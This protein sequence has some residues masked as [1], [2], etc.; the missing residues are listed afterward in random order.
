MRSESLRRRAQNL[1]CTNSSI[2]LSPS[3]LQQSSEPTP[4]P[5]LQVPASLRHPALKDDEEDLDGSQA[6]DSAL[7]SEG[8]HSDALDSDH[9]IAPIDEGDESKED[10]Q[11][12]ST[13]NKHEVSEETV[14]CPVGVGKDS[15]Y[16]DSKT[17]DEY[18]VSVRPP[19]RETTA[20]SPPP[21]RQVGQKGHKFRSKK[22][23]TIS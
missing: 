11:T 9:P 18:S 14:T 4:P 6:K 22:I 15:G 2:S 5:P 19:Q 8:N 7:G 23:V 10:L 3:A 20:R 17:E 16:S 13:E 21:H 12:R 1:T